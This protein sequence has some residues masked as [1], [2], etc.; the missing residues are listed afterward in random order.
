MNRYVSM[1]LVENSNNRLIFT[2]YPK[3]HYN[4]KDKKVFMRTLLYQPTK[5][6]TTMQFYIKSPRVNV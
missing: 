3:K 5:A 2:K 4:P 6:A 1:P